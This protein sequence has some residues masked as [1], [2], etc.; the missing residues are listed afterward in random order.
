[1]SHSKPHRRSAG[2]GVRTGPCDADVADSRG[3]Y[4]FDAAV[5]VRA[6]AEIVEK[7]A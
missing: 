7:I 5:V 6:G 4:M 3:T 2:Y 1:V